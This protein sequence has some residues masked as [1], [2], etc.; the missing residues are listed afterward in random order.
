M[1]HSGAPCWRCARQGGTGQAG[2]LAGDSRLRC[3]S[4]RLSARAQ[5][6]IARMGLE[7][8][9][10]VSARPLA[11]LAKPTHCPLPIGLLICNPPYGERLGEKEQLA[12]AL[13]ATGGGHGC[14]SSAVGRRLCS[15]PTWNWARP[16][17][18]AVTSA[19]HCGTAL[20]LHTLLLFDLVDNQLR[21]SAPGSQY[22]RATSW[23][24]AGA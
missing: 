7:K 17:G 3:R 21:A 4:R 11:E 2:T 6:N 18:C 23:Q 12:R 22:R 5:E 10:R 19:M 14:G 13:S 15:P 24:P 20:S 16:Q 8:V 9:V 1:K